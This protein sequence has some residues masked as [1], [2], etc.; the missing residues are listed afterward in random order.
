LFNLF[1]IKRRKE[2]IKAPK[3]ELQSTNKTEVNA[4]KRKLSSS[5]EEEST[6]D[7][8][9]DKHEN[10]AIVPSRVEVQSETT[11]QIENKN[12]I[13]LSGDDSIW[14]NNKQTSSLLSE[15]KNSKENDFEDYLE[16]LLF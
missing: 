12:M 1:L 9:K 15:D 14:K 7:N 4:K 11:L 13:M 6:K 10:K 8:N 16:D 2:V 3:A 5:D